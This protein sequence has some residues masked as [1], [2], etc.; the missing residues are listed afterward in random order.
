MQLIFVIYSNPN[1]KYIWAKTKLLAATKDLEA[2][3]NVLSRFNPT[4]TEI[5]QFKV[6]LLLS[7][8]TTDS[9]SEALSIYEQA[10]AGDLNATIGKCKCYLRLDKQRD[11]TRNINGIIHGEATHS[12]FSIFAEAFL[13][14][15]YISLKDGQIDEADKYVERALDLN[16]SCGKAWELK[17]IIAEKKKEFL[18]AADAYKMAWNLSGHADLGIGFKLAVNYMRSGRAAR[19]VPHFVLYTHE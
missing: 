5:D 8:N 17:G 10:E 15:T 13:M 18:Y 16:K 19:G 7:Q 1:R 4:V 11:I 14:M 3:K 6:L 12:N 9:V 2:A